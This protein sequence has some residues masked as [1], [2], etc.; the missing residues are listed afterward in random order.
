MGAQADLDR[1]RQ[2]MADLKYRDLTPDELFEEQQR[3]M[4]I[5]R[6]LNREI[7]RC[8]TLPHRTPDQPVLNLRPYD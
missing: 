5:L 7:R 1:S 2:R 3:E 6:D 4:Q 8:R